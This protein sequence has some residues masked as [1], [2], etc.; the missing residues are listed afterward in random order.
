[1]LLYMAEYA[2]AQ[3]ERSSRNKDFGNMLLTY[4]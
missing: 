4:L 1:M 2:K 3:L